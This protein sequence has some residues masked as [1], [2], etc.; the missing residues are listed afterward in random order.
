MDT[1]KTEFFLFGDYW[2]LYWGHPDVPKKHLRFANVFDHAPACQDED[3]HVQ[4]DPQADCQSNDPEAGAVRFW[5]INPAT[6]AARG[7][8]AFG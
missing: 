7:R 5:K 8:K 1:Y 3:T 2:D 6:R 4:K